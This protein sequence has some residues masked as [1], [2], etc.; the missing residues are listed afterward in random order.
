MLQDNV[1]DGGV[2]AALLKE[3]GIKEAQMIE[4]D[5]EIADLIQEKKDIEDE[6]NEMEKSIA[7]M[8]AKQL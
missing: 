3:Q 7:A 2:E 4:R 1:G 6:K 5:K 8:K